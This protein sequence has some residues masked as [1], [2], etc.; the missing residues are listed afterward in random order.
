MGANT[1]PGA[2]AASWARRSGVEA[3]AWTSQPKRRAIWIG[4]AATP[5]LYFAVWHL[6]TDGGI[7]ITGSHNPP[8]YN[9]FK[10]CVG[11]GSLHGAGILALRDRIADN[12]IKARCAA[13]LMCHNRL[14]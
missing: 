9:G 13:E 12:D 6:E 14:L 7:Q 11:T 4:V 5:M 3:V 1:R 2:S 10:C 8:E